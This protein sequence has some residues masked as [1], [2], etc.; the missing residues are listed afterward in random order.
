MKT[1]WPGFWKNMAI[2][3]RSLSTAAGYDLDA[4]AKAVLSGLG[5]AEREFSQPVE[6][7]SGRLE[8]AYRPG[9]NTH[10]QP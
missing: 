4:R 9:Q 6:T 3:L 2:S 7:Y 1:S 8:D 10:H 5:F